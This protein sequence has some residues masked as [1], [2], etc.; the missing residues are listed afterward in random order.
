MDL[1]ARYANEQFDL[2][3]SDNNQQLIGLGGSLE[4]QLND[5]FKGI[6]GVNFTRQLADI[7][8]NQYSETIIS[9][10]LQKRF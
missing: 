9:I 8:A 6:L 5:T 10:G 1:T 3:S 7:P 4:Y 2:G